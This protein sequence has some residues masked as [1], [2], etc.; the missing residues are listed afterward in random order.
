MALGQEFILDLDPCKRSSGKA[1]RVSAGRYFLIKRRPPNPIHPLDQT[2]CK[3]SWIAINTI[4][5]AR[6]QSIKRSRLH[7]ARGLTSPLASGIFFFAKVAAQT[8]AT[9]KPL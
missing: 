5:V 1:D 8:T 4:T 9:F 7:S 6:N 3:T 2:K